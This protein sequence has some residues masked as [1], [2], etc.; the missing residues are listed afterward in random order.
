MEHHYNDIELF[1]PLTI[2]VLSINSSFAKNYSPYGIFHPMKDHYIDVELYTP[3]TVHAVS[4][5]S[6]S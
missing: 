1:K 5:D 4:I 2:H 6:K 3:L